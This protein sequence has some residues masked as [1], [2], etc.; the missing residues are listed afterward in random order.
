M[1]IG[2]SGPQ[3][4]PMKPSTLEVRNSKVKV[5][6]GRR[7]KDR[8]GGLAEAPTQLLTYLDYINN[9]YL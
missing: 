9:S 3:G 2:T 1:P 4:K 8:F 6:Q 5:I 7:A